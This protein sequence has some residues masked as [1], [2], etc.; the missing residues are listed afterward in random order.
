MFNKNKGF[1]SVAKQRIQRWAVYLSTF[2]YQL[3]YRKGSQI[4][5]ADALSRLPLE[6]K[7]GLEEPAI[8]NFG[9][10]SG[11][12]LTL[13]DI[14]NETGKDKNL[15]VIREALMQGN[16]NNL[17]L[18]FKSYLNFKCS[19][20][21]EGGCIFYGDRVFIPEL[22]QERVL[23][24]LHDTHIG[25]VRMKLLARSCVWWLGLD[26]AINEY[27]RSCKVCT[28]SQNHVKECENSEWPRTNKPY[29]RIHL[30]L[31]HIGKFNFLVAIDHYSKWMD[32]YVMKE[33]S[34]KS[35]KDKLRVQ[36]ANFGLPKIIVTDNG[37]PFS[38]SEF[39]S[40]CH[41]N[42]INLVHSPPYHPQSNG[43]AE[44]AVQDI[45]FQNV[46][47]LV[48]SF[49][50]SYRNT[51][52]TITG[53]S[54]SEIIFNHKPN[55][56][57]SLLNKESIVKNEKRESYVSKS[58]ENIQNNCKENIQNNCNLNNFDL[59]VND[60]V[61]YMNNFKNNFPKWWDAKILARISKFVYKIIVNG[62]VRTAHRNQLRLKNQNLKF[63][64]YPTTRFM[65]RGR[66]RNF[67]EIMSPTSDTRASRTGYNLRE[68]KY[69]RDRFYSV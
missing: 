40:F 14:A 50:F 32:V 18:S 26:K 7:T 5:N 63:K 66:K 16:L 46:Q 43:L 4:R 69:V 59:K 34:A 8:L 12:T 24:M 37:P 11:I 38:S 25:V 6:E 44:R 51:P 48:N 19:L 56:F 41:S 23:R 65:A 30:D 42:G 15:V 22:F 55:T 47:E 64:Y 20:S 39:A 35:V 3:C 68:L 28:S 17:P 1:P 21:A 13:H 36:F 57:L 60:L 54:P 2:D 27:V 9:L 52:S 33:Y 29:D 10:A 45:N 61:L 31:C 62:S 53:M 49:L 67:S 58:K